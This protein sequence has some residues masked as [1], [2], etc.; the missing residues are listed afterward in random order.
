MTTTLG[1]PREPPAMVLHKKEP[2]CEE[3]LDSGMDSMKEDEYEQMVHELQE[4]RL[5]P[6]PP[7]PEPSQP[8]HGQRTED[9]DTFLHL[10]IIHKAQEQALRA[11]HLSS[12][13]LAFLN[14]QNHLRQTPLHLAV[15]TEQPQITHALLKAGCD[16]DMRDFNG[17]TALH[18][19][20]ERGSL[21]AVG[22]L[23]QYC[24]QKQLRGLL[25]A[26][27]YNGHTC[28]HVATL[29]GF[30]ALVESL[31]SLGADI[32]VQEP[33]NGRTALHLAVDLQNAALV[34][35]LVKLGANVNCVTFQGY[36]PFQL[37]WG[38]DNQ[39]IRSQLQSLTRSSLHD[40][41]DSEDDSAQSDSDFSDDEMLYD[42][43]QLMGHP[44]TG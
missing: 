13:N 15:V 34:S 31:V 27:N 12:S 32:D 26:I 36:S 40:L 38:R 29:H 7:A 19:A 33:C 21:R 24:S 41:P 10:A 22:V 4:I 16:P 3:R 43:C 23:T 6:A 5:A 37:T 14:T 39:Q 11:V 8:W 18:L 44:L 17:N 42:D 28:L 25:Q 35:L 20:C 9:G 2:A 30:L 1:G